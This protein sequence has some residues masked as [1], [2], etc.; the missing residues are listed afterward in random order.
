MAVHPINASTFGSTSGG[1]SPIDAIDPEHA[2]S[3]A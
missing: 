1:K 2:K 3:F